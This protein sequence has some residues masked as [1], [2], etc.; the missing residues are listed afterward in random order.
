MQLKKC[1]TKQYDNTRTALQAPISEP[2]YRVLWLVNGKEKKSPY[3]YKEEHAKQLL[4]TL[5]IKHGEKNAIIYI[6]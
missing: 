6:N 1:K 3:L 5:R 2:A 4:T